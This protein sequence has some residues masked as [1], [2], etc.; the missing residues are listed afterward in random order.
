MYLYSMTRFYACALLLLAF[1]AC[2]ESAPKQQQA[3]EQETPAAIATLNTMVLVPGGQYNMGADD[4]HGMPDEYP[5]HNVHI[6]SFWIDEHEV[7]NAEFAAFVKATGYITTAQRPISK[8]EYMRGMP[9]GTPEPDSTDLLPGALVFTPTDHAV[10]LNDVS[11]WWTFTLA[12]DWQHPSGPDSDISGKEHYPVVQ[13]SWED[14]MAFAKWAGKRLPTEAEWEVAARGG[15]K[16][17]PYPWGAE[18]PQAGKPKANIWSGHFPYENTKTDSFYNTAPVKSFAA[19]GYRLYD[20]SGNVWEWT[21]DWYSTHSYKEDRKDASGP[22]TPFDQA[23][24]ASPK[25]VIRG[26][27]FMC[28]DE[29]CRGYRVSARMKTTPESGLSNLGFRCARSIR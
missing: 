14:A 23:D 27:S 9:P 13:V 8:E 29:Y 15:L 18:A 26:G 10:D 21:A 19:N 2:Q 5:K 7:T 12:A 16:G 22:A 25:R 28:S 4:E 1:T 3:V 11:Q 20:M 17:Q 24:P 6:D